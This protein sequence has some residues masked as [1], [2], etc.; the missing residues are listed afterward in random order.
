MSCIVA[1]GAIVDAIRETKIA[2]HAEKYS[3]SV[4]TQVT[5]EDI[6]NKLQASLIRKETSLLQCTI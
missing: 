6:F 4:R 3:P 5:A 1:A 2:T